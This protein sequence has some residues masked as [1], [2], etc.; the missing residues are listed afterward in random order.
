MS[1]DQLNESETADRRSQLPLQD[2]FDDVLK[3]SI[4]Q[5]DT[6]GEAE[7]LSDFFANHAIPEQIDR[8]QILAALITDIESQKEK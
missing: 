8:A 7:L 3:N 5:P 2:D 6:K 4:I 1:E